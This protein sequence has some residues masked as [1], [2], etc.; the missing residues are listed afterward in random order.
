MV[1]AKSQTRFERTPASAAPHAIRG[2]E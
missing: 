1:Y 2:S